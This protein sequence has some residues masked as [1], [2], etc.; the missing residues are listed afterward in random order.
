VNYEDETLVIGPPS[1]KALQD[2][3]VPAQE[4]VSNV[5]Y[6]PFQNFKDSLS[7]DVESE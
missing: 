3:T 1:D 4:E 2:P 7:Y 6:F 5:S